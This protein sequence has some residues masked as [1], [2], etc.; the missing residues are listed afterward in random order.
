M[1]ILAALVMLS[2]TIAFA[3][4][5]NPMMRV[6]RLSE[7]QFWIVQNV[8]DGKDIPLCVL[9]SAAIGAETLMQYS[10]KNSVPHAVN[11]YKRGGQT[12]VGTTR[13]EAKD[14]E[15][16][17]WRLCRFADGSIIERTTLEAGVGAPENAA[18]NQALQ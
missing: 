11:Y 9:G 10:F 18:L 13:L 2:S 17:S 6:C 15:G 7:G 4:N 3:N 5:N 14:S 12:C 1:K 16:Q 8:A